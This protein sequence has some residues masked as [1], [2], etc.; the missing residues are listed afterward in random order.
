M[1][2]TQINNRF[3]KIY[4]AHHDLWLL[5]YT[6]C[7][8]YCFIYVGMTKDEIPKYKPLKYLFSFIT[9]YKKNILN[10]YILWLFFRCEAD[11]FYFRIQ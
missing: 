9:L 3:K 5:I 11:V 8:Y 2:F 4:I 10:I 7:F 1:S 6:K